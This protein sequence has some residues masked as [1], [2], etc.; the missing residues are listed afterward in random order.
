MSR[1]RPVDRG[2]VALATVASAAMIAL[3]LSG[4][5]AGG[6]EGADQTV[7]NAPFAYYP[8]VDTGSRTSFADG[9]VYCPPGG[10][11]TYVIRLLNRAGNDLAYK[12]GG[13]YG[14]EGVWYLRTDGW[15][16]CAGAYVRSHIW[17]NT[18]GAHKSDTSGENPNCA[19]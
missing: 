13:P 8:F 19:Y 10:G 18:A 5:A 1:S 3:V 4:V 2:L 11:F 7:C 9:E 14:G 16:S 15:V 12:S 6:S 17:I